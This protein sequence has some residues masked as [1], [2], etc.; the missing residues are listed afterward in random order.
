MLIDGLPA[1]NAL[2]RAV[3]VSAAWTLDQ[4]L[5]ALAVDALRAANWQRGGD[6]KA[7]RPEPI[8][9]PGVAEHRR[10]VEERIL[11]KARAF[12]ARHGIE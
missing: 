2:A 8:E 10:G 9:R 7:P 3:D 1:D 5:L 11:A 6:A 4:H 12:Q